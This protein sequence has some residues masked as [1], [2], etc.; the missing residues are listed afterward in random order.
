MRVHRR[1]LY[2]SALNFGSRINEGACKLSED[3]KSGEVVKF[4]KNISFIM[5]T[6]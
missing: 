4:S 2:L 3:K 5:C 6:C 1:R